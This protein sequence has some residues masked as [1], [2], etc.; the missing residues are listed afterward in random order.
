[1]QSQEYPLGITAIVLNPVERL[2]IA[3]SIDGRIF[4]TVLD[5]GLLEDPFVVEEDQPVVLKGHK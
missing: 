5:I 4:V 2:L 3:G 1:M